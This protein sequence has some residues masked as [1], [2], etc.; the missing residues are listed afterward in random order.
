MNNTAKI[1]TRDNHFWIKFQDGMEIDL[2]TPEFIPLPFWKK[3]FGWIKNLLSI[4]KALPC[5]LPRR[6]S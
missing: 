4:R 3:P 6:H 2:G 5:S 1:F